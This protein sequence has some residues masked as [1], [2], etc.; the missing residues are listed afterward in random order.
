MA[1]RYTKAPEDYP[2]VNGC[3]VLP[4]RDVLVI[5]LHLASHHTLKSSTSSSSTVCPTHKTTRAFSCFS[6]DPFA[7]KARK[8]CIRAKGRGGDGSGSSES[9][10][11]DHSSEDEE[12]LRPTKRGACQPP[13][14][15]H[16]QAKE[17]CRRREDDVFACAMLEEARKGPAPDLFFFLSGV[18][19]G[20]NLA[21]G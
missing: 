17:V 4:L 13:A 20:R 10:S 11:S 21:A 3:W 7:F 18:A 1:E 8:R 12:L 16:I 19:W 2:W 15:Q 6:I 9:S 5:Y 14:W